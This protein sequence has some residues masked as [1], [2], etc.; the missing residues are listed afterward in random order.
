M[1]AWTP[2]SVRRPGARPPSPGSARAGRDAEPGDR[3]SCGVDQHDRA[4]EVGLHPRGEGLGRPAREPGL[5]E[6]RYHLPTLGN[7]TATLAN[8]T[9]GL[10][11]GDIHGGGI[12]ADGNT[13][14]ATDGRNWSD[15]WV[16]RFFRRTAADSQTAH[17][18][19]VGGV[20]LAHHGTPT[21]AAS[22]DQAF[23]GVIGAFGA[24][25]E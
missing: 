5:Q 7:W 15:G 12:A 25:K 10:T 22:N 8:E 14:G 18:T 6:R 4:V 21:M 19:A 11:G 16:A 2:R 20:F 3:R 9:G 24:G 13:A 17:P 1:T 23:V